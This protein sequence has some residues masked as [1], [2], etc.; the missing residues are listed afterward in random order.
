MM[1]KRRCASR[2]WTRRNSE[3]KLFFL[4]FFLPHIQYTDED[5][6]GEEDDEEEEVLRGSVRIKAVDPAEF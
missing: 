5:E 2:R 1:R 6:D 4:S 3:L